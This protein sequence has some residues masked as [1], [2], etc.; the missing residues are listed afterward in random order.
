MAV[1][2]GLDKA[3]ELVGVAGNDRLQRFTGFVLRNGRGDRLGDRGRAGGDL[4]GGD[5]AVVSDGDVAP[6]RPGSSRPGANLASG[7]GVIVSDAAAAEAWK[8]LAVRLTSVLGWSAPRRRS[9]SRRLRSHRAGTA[10]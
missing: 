1:L 6:V 2:D 3:F 8:E 5:G 4:I 9:D 10:S 7:V